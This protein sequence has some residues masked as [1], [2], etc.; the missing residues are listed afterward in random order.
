VSWLL[1]A[2]WSAFALATAVLY[3]L[4]A[5]ASGS[6][7]VGLHSGTVQGRARARMASWAR[8]ER[9]RFEDHLG[10]CI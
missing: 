1:F 9:A 7:T 2:L 6:A 10:A 8:V 4:V 3:A 5:C